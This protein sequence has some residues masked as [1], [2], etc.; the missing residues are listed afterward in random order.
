MSP[1]EVLNKKYEKA[2]SELE[3]QTKDIIELSR[4]LS[5]FTKLLENIESQKS[6]LDLVAQLK[7]EILE[8]N[9]IASELLNHSPKVFNS[10]ED[11]VEQLLEK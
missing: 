6:N 4:R 2:K 5:I 11:L 3:G 7:K 1:V 8:T 9:S 10:F